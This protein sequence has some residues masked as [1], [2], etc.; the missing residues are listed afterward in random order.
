MW[1]ILV[2]NWPLLLRYLNWLGEHL[3]K[4]F[5]HVF[6]MFD[7]SVH[8]EEFA[9]ISSNFFSAGLSIRE[10]KPTVS[11]HRDTFAAEWIQQRCRNCYLPVRWLR[12][13]SD[14]IRSSPGL[15]SAVQFKRVFPFVLPVRRTLERRLLGCS[16]LIETSRNLRSY[17]AP[18]LLT[19][20][21]RKDKTAS[22]SAHLVG[23]IV[24]PYPLSRRKSW[25]GRPWCS[26]SGS[27]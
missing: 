19:R 23:L 1:C 24:K 6:R 3:I 4:T 2:V 12:L 8:R 17:L 18:S 21:P 15:L 26:S 9:V 5:N 27:V 20:C 14:A 10:K 22:P 7:S 11:N 13:V 25:F 16:V